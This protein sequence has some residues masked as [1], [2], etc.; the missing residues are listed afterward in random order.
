MLLIPRVADLTDFHQLNHS[1]QQQLMQEI[2]LADQALR[3]VFPQVKK[4]NQG[5]LSM[6]VEQFHWHLVGRYPQDPLWPRPVWGNKVREDYTYCEVGQLVPQL[7]Q[8]L[9]TEN[10]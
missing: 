9:E 2:A 1:Q 7:E 8:A 5:F 6:V 4:V 3:A 10:V